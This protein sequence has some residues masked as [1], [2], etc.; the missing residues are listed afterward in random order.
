MHTRLIS[1]IA[2]V[3]AT[4][5]IIHYNYDEQNIKT[6]IAAQLKYQI[7]W[8]AKKCQTSKC[9]LYNYNINGFNNLC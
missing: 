6:K 8:L 4:G 1:G 9:P 3:I 2:I 7:K 5:Y